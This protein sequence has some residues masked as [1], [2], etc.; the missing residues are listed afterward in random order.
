MLQIYIGHIRE[1]T[2]ALENRDKVRVD[3]VAVKSVEG[4]SGGIS[5]ED[6]ENPML[7]FCICFCIQNGNSSGKSCAISNN[8]I[9]W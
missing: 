4:L 9:A 8:S 1:Y 3:W 7:A 5:G 6:R 2:K